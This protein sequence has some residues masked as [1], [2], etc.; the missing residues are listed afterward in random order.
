MPRKSLTNVVAFDDAPFDRRSRDRVPV[1][2]AVFADLR[3]DGVLIGDVA[4]DGDD[5]ADALITLTERSRFREHVRLVLLQGVALAG[6]NVVDA[7]AVHDRLGVPVLIVA[8]RR[9]DREA[10][11]EALLSRVQGGARKWS[12]IERLGPMEEMGGVFVQRVGLSTSDA[13]A[14]TTR[15]AVHGSV[16]EPL[17]VAHLIAGALVRGES[18]GRV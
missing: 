1:V 10:I 2:G 4:R 5:A 13:A 6:F 12:L 15:L 3:F 16:P 8:R 7:F 17:R 9:P 14:V 11:R 18:R